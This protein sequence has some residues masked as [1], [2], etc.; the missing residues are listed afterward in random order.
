MTAVLTRPLPPDTSS[1]R[2]PTPLRPQPEI[3]TPV[4]VVDQWGMHSF[5]ASDP[6]SNW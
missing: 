5:P 6:P 2:A 3:S 1:A 4:D